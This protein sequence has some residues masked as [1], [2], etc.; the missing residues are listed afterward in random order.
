MDL[1]AVGP[2]EVSRG[3][4]AGPGSVYFVSLPVGQIVSES[5]RLV[6]AGAHVFLDTRQMPPAADLE[7]LCKIAHE[8]GVSVGVSRPL[9]FATGLSDFVGKAGVAVLE[10]EFGE[11]P[12]AWTRSLTDTLDLSIHLCG[13]SS[14]RRIEASSDR[15]DRVWPVFGAF[16]LRFDNGA[17][18]I[19]SLRRSTPPGE[20]TRCILSRDAVV[21]ER[22]A[23]V[24]EDAI[25]AETSDFLS[26]VA[27]GSVP[28]VSVSETLTTVRLVDHVLAL[29]R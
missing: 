28:T 20:V 14:A 3:A 2:R 25:Q 4:P 15:R 19:G 22:E 29:L 23:A 26:C 12:E 5:L 7:R 27:D 24:S 11:E 13:R 10:A 21:E 8:A 16:S 17:L 6:R 18:A 9:R 1:S